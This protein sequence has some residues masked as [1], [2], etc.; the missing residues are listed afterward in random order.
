MSEETVEIEGGK[1]KSC[2]RCT[3][4]NRSYSIRTY[5]KVRVFGRFWELQD[6]SW[7]SRKDFSYHMEAYHQICTFKHLRIEFF[8]DLSYTENNLDFEIKRTKNEAKYIDFFENLK[9]IQKLLKIGHKN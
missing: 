5:H 9:F 1:R 4:N 8:I 2:T 3:T 6:L 7:G